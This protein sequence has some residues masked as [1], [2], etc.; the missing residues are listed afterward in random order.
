MNRTSIEV[1]ARRIAKRLKKL[2]VSVEELCALFNIGLYF[3]DLKHFDAYYM[4]KGGRRIIVVNDALSKRDSASRSPTSLRTPFW[5]TARSL[6]TP[7][8]S[9]RHGRRRKPTTSQQSYSCP[10]PCSFNMDT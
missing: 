9:A 5:T 10:N 2:P 4:T 3:T 8:H 1:A 7:T 6:L